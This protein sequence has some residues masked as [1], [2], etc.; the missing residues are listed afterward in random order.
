MAHGLESF[1]EHPG[2]EFPEPGRLKE[3][4]C[5]HRLPSTFVDCLLNPD[6]EGRQVLSLDLILPTSYSEIQS[7]TFWLYPGQ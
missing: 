2:T 4:K 7:T 3:I 5:S 6:V 1:A